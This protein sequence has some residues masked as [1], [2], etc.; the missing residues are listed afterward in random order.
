M[1][2]LAAENALA[3]YNSLIVSICRDLWS[4]RAPS[5]CDW[6]DV[7]QEVRL[8]ILQG[9][10]N[11]SADHAADDIR[12]EARNA[13]KRLTRDAHM[14]TASSDPAVE[15]LFYSSSGRAEH[16]LLD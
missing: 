4:R 7:A 14:V 11:V 2:T 9:K 10:R 1:A 13:L 15:A 5:T 6:E 3:I 12:N 8:A 16:A